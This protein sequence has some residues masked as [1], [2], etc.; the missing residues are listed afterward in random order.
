MQIIVKCN[1]NSGFLNLQALFI[2]LLIY[3]LVCQ[4][5]RPGLDVLSFLFNPYSL[6]DYNIVLYVRKKNVCFNN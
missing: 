6:F 1:L 3:H 5:Y 4:H 2:D